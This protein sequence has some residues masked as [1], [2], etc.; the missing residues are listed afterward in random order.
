MNLYNGWTKEISSEQRK[1]NRA[2]ALASNA[3]LLAWHNALRQ[4]ARIAALFVGFEVAV[5]CPADFDTVQS[6]IIR[7]QNAG[8]WN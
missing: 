8:E 6:E 1:A 4:A 5:A 3:D 2:C 7:R